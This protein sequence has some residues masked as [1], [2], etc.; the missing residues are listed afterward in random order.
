MDTAR[1]A[2]VLTLVTKQN[3]SQKFAFSIISEGEILN[4]QNHFYNSQQV[5]L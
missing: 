3:K 2:R 5:I 1:L 4:S